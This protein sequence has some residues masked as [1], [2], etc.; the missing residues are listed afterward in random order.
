MK[1]LVTGGTGFI[2]RAAV[3]ALSRLGCEVHV[4]TRGAGAQA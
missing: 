4:V 1:V 3:A 2:G